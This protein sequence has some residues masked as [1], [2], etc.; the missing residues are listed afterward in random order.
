MIIV[1]KHGKYIKEITCPQ[2]ECVFL[3]NS[4]SREGDLKYPSQSIWD[5]DEEY[6]SKRYIKCPECGHLIWEPDKIV[7]DK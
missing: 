3:Y 4:N 1:K 6:I 2:C 5:D 7:E